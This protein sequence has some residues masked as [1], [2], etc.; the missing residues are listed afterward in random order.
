[1]KKTTAYARKCA[2]KKRQA[3][4]ENLL[5]QIKR[6]LRSL[7]IDAGIHTWTGND[8]AKM[9][10]KAA[11][12]CY[13]AAYACPRSGID[14]D[15]PDVRIVRGMSEA[16]ADLASDLDNIEQHRPA[17]QSG[18]AAIDRLL[19]DC[20]VMKIIEGALKLDTILCAKH[21]G[22]ADIREAMGVTP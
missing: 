10:D 15:H 14:K 1:M 16:L 13:I 18:L 3:E 2:I 21:L 9:V 11:R 17:L 6:D 7:Q 4:H 22:T 5:A 20:D 19:E 12:L 8:G